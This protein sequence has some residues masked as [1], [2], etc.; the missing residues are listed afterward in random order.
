MHYR[1]LEAHDADS[2]LGIVDRNDVQVDLLLTDVVLPGMN[3][4]QLAEALKVRQPGIRVLF[5]SGYSR[6]AIVHEGRLDPGVELMQKPLTQEV[7]EEKIRAILDSARWPRQQLKEKL[8]LD[9]FE[10]RS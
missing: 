1:V 3:G 7:L 6:D 2:A 10:G 9:H 5:M 4:R 8:G